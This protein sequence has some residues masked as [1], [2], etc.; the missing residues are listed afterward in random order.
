M[1]ACD[2]ESVKPDILILGKA[3][4]GGVL[5][6]SAVLADDPV[7]TLLRP[8]EHGS[9]Y[10]GNPL[11][12]RVAMSALDVLIDE[13]LDENSAKMGKPETPYLSE[14]FSLLSPNLSSF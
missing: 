7:M 8:G 6:V 13:K 11:S 14:L 4:S 3:L 10:G 9:T 1:L 5:P 12:A 2:H